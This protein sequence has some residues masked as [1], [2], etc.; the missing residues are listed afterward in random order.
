MDRQIVYP[1]AI[2]LDTDFLSLNRAAMVAIGTLARAVLGTTTVAD[3]LACQPTTPASLTV[4]VGAGSITA[5][6]PV[7]SLSYG[8]LGADTTHQVVRIGINLDPTSF[9]LT[10]P[11][12]P[13]Q[14]ITYLI[15][16]AFDEEDAGPVV[17]PYVNAANPSQ[18]Y[19]GPDNSG[20]SQNT[21][22]IQRVQLQLKAGAAANTGS[23]TAP[24]VDAGWS[25]LY[26]ITV[27][28]GQTAITAAQIATHPAAPFLSYKLPRLTPGFSRRITFGASTSF[29][30]PLGV[31]LLRASV[32]GGGGGGGGS[33][34]SYAGAGGGAGGYASGTFTVTPGSTIAVTVG[35]GGVG[36]PAGS[37]AGNGGNSIFGALLSASGG[38][39]GQFQNTSSTP[40]GAGGAGSGGE[41]ATLGGYGADGQNGAT[42]IGG[43]GGQSVLGGGGRA[44]TAGNTA[45]NGQAAGSGGGGTYNSAG[46]GGQGA[47]GLVILEY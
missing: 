10:P 2:P 18:P 38:Q 45:L 19:S 26:L 6:G 32:V 42:V 37:A 9:T 41:L 17:L 30:V 5:L 27:N 23:Q 28:N 35:A 16:A 3:G 22:R 39:G 12:T 36:G 29:T 43:H 8:S 14:S 47:A 25:G 4:T 40:G 13:G 44:S 1:G 46:N 34:G 21:Q 31:T 33:N 20:T 15:E 11:P 7:D 24:A